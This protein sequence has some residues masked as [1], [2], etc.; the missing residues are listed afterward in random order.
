MN[1][2]ITNLLKKSSQLLATVEN[3]NKVH[4]TFDKKNNIV[5]STGNGLFYDIGRVRNVWKF[6]SLPTRAESRIIVGA[7]GSGKSAAIIQSILCHAV[8]M[9]KCSDGIRRS[10]WAL[11][12][13]TLSQLETTTLADWMTWTKFLPPAIQNKS[14][15][16]QY[17]Y[18]FNCDKDKIE[19]EIL[20]IPLDH[21][22]DIRK[23]K[24]LQLTGAYINELSEIPKCIFDTITARITRYPSKDY[25]KYF[26]KGKAKDYVKWFPYQGI[27]LCDSNATDEDHW[28]PKLEA[29]QDELKSIEIYHQPPSCIKDENGKWINNPEAD[30]IMSQ[31]PNH[32]LN[33]LDKGEEFFRVYALGEY[34]SVSAGLPIYPEFQE[35]WH[36]ADDL[37]N[38][39]EKDGIYYFGWDF[40]LTPAW[41]LGQR[42]SSGQILILHEIVTD[43]EQQGIEQLASFKVI[44]YINDKLPNKPYKSLADPAGMAGNQNNNISNIQVLNK[45]GIRTKAA[46]TNNP[47]SRQ[48]A[49]RNY[50][51]KNLCGQA[52]IKINRSCRTLIKALKSKYCWMRVGVIGKER[53][54]NVPHK[55][56]P[57][58]D[59]V[60]C[61]EYILLEFATPIP[62]KKEQIDLTIR[63]NF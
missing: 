41:L 4:A 18:T 48:N 32:Y 56:H 62:V 52:A 40:G 13:N 44:P 20:L 26:Y 36:V 42:L 50:F 29:R 35:S 21:V 14:P 60:D 54:K 63:S 23:L 25:F 58:S 38:K 33:Y 43:D 27:L 15:T 39:T 49:V 47:E 31:H 30:N 57:Y 1:Q 55:I 59:I 28:L 45:L 6:L 22:K 5:R 17:K 2:R 53:Y 11:V 3:L 16:W 10:K 7:F 19:L 46:R 51:N 61:L 12:R 8:Q 34:G 24:S 9:P 37:W